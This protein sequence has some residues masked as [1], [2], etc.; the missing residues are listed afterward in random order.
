MLTECLESNTTLTLQGLE[1]QL[2]EVVKSLKQAWGVEYI[3]AW[4]GL[5]AYWAGVAVGELYHCC[6]A[7]ASAALLALA[8]LC[9]HCASSSV[10]IPAGPAEH[11][12]PD[13]SVMLPQHAGLALCAAACCCTL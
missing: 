11:P 9:H 2:G 12:G 10:L 5:P 3:Y 1:P 8:S 7:A 6:R 4:H 13:P